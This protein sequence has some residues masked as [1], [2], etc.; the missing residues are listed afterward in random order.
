MVFSTDFHIYIFFCKKLKNI[1]IKSFYFPYLFLY[2]AIFS[3]KLFISSLS[4]T[5]LPQ[6]RVALHGV[7]YGIFREEEVHKIH[8]M[9]PREDRQFRLGDPEFTHSGWGWAESGCEQIQ[10]N[11]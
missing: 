11:C 4:G 2:E 1:F 3:V 7:A 9:V 6:Q 5:F 10:L 8:R